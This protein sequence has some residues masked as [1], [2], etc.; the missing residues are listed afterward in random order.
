[1]S[2]YAHQKVVWLDVTMNEVFVVYILNA[3]NHLYTGQKVS[4]S[5][6]KC[7]SDTKCTQGSSH[8]YLNYQR[9]QE[10]VETLDVGQTNVGE[11]WA[12]S[13]E[14]DLPDLPTST[15]SS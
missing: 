8:F 12:V 11:N 13:Q 14:R 15:L 2:A 9:T 5:V 3:A 4:R 10:V 6:K 7:Q 1:M